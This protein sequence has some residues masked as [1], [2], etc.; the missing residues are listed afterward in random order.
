MWDVL[1]RADRDRH[2]R[3]HLVPALVEAGTRG[4]VRLGHRDLHL[5]RGA[6]HGAHG[7]HLTA[8]G[9]ARSGVLLHAPGPDAVAAIRRRGRRRSTAPSLRP[10]PRGSSAEP[11]RC[12]SGRPSGCSR[13]SSGCSRSTGPATPSPN[14]MAGT[15]AGEPGWY[16]HLLNSFGHAFVG[17]GIGV[18]VILAALS[19]VI[20]PGPLGVEPASGVHRARHR[21]GPSL[22]G[23]RRGTGRALDG[24]RHGPQQRA[25]RGSD[26]ALGPPARPGPDRRA[27][28]RRPPHGRSSARSRPHG[29]RPRRRPVGGRG[30]PDRRVATAASATIVRV[31]G[32][33]VR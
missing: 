14:Q 12:W 13:P 21:A 4:V 16:A 24:L 8:A 31:I 29:P 22:L 18:A 2:R 28:S 20:A 7:R 19:L 10:R 11:G 26:R 32:Q 27:H 3:G 30:R 33:L 5:R 25:H 1:F 23:H 15:S 9:C 17:A 6:R